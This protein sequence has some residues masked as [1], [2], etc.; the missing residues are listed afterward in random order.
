MRCID[1][2]RLSSA[3]RRRNTTARPQTSRSGIVAARHQRVLTARRERQQAEGD[4]E[5][6]Q[7]PTTARPTTA[8]RTTARPTTARPTTARP[9][10]AGARRPGTAW[11]QPGTASGRPGSSAPRSAAHPSWSMDSVTFESER[12]RLNTIA[13]HQAPTTS[14]SSPVT[15][16]TAPVTTILMIDDDDDDFEQVMQ[17]ATTFRA[18]L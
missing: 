14:P 2:T 5:Q 1:K 7:R 4:A 17:T 8:R 18:E 12:S 13:E 15:T 10:T 9:T 3:T 11:G 6:A 16:A